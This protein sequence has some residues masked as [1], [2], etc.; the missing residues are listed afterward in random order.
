LPARSREDFDAKFAWR[1]VL[2]VAGVLFHPRRRT[3]EDYPKQS[4][5]SQRR[6]VI[7]QK[8]IGY[9]CKEVLFMSAMSV[10]KDFIGDVS[11]VVSSDRPAAAHLPVFANC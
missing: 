3:P 7:G 2:A 11:N 5:S 10:A 4:A 9:A 8:I 6:P 1:N